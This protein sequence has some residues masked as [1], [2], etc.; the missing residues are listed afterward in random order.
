MATTKLL[1]IRDVADT[2][3]YIENP[4][5]TVAGL[6]ALAAYAAH[7]ASS[8]G[9]SEHSEHF[10]TLVDYVLRGDKTDIVR[11]VTGINCEPETAA[12]EME[13]TRERFDK[14]DTVRQGYHLIQSFQPGE[15]APEVAHK[16]GV[17]MAQRLLGDRFEVVVSTHIDREHIHNH[18][19]WNSVS[20]VDGKMA[21]Y[22]KSFYFKDVRGTSD[23]LCREHHLSVVLPARGRLNS[24]LEV[25]DAATGM[26][27]LDE[28]KGRARGRG[29][30][31]VRARVAADM[32]GIIAQSKTWNEFIANLRSAGYDVRHG[33]ELKH[34]AI[35][36][37]SGTKIRTASLGARYTE[38][39]LRER[40]RR[41]T[42][43]PT[44]AAA[45]ERADEQ[46]KNGA[47]KRSAAVRGS[48]KPTKLRGYRALYFRY[49]YMLGKVKKRG[50]SRRAS[51][52]LTT[53]A[54]RLKATIA[55]EQFLRTNKL[56]THAELRLYVAATEDEIYRLSAERAPLYRTRANA[57]LREELTA[58]IRKHRANLRLANNVEHDSTE[59]RNELKAAREFAA[60]P[61]QRRAAAEREARER[62]AEL[63]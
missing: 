9:Y 61:K 53:S 16:I 50:M 45:L 63:S 7:I 31:T 44:I 62:G 34:F 43:N 3:D 40:V 60:T 55:Q 41:N 32:D 22:N 24:R 56:S 39:A 33:N 54:K 59:I 27:V 29:N 48:Y 19:A 10:G 4:D 26:R 8:R 18:I 30:N 15:V 14:T 47:K 37:P 6:D 52:Y 17:E 13:M 46:R 11:F 23:A 5:K 12:R 25:T 35:R 58:R 49:L 21:H 42:M 2:V 20:C 28:P 36:T 57:E 1:I 51:R 38:D